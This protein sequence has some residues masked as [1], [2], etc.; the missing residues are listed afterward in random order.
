MQ[1][2]RSPAS[3][4]PR[5]RRNRITLACALAAVILLGLGARRF[6]GLLPAFLGKY[7]GDALWALA[8]MIGWGM[9]WP[10]A[11]TTGLATLA[12]ATSCAV[13]FS[14]LWKVPWLDDIRHTTIGHLVLGS[15]FAWP[16]LVAYAV[17][18][19]IGVGLDRICQTKTRQGRL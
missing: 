2:P 18:V 8:V 3:N 17:G 16:D 7:P 10:R 14:Q 9:V 1:E 5:P 6:P 15:G 12:L 19:V 11:S 13:E 4:P